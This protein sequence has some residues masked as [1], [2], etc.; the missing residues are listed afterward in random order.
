MYCTVFVEVK[1]DTIKIGI[2]FNIGF[3]KTNIQNPKQNDFFV[4]NLDAFS[5]PIIYRYSK[6]RLQSRGSVDI[7][8]RITVENVCGE[9]IFFRYTN[10][11]KMNKHTIG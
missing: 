4:C 11:Q 9:F 3:A 1:T 5:F 8:L 7:F 2:L 6:Y 10:Y